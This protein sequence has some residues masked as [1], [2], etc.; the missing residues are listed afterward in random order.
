MLS[1]VK[2]TFKCIPA[3]R[4]TEGSTQG[5]LP[6]QKEG[7]AC[8]NNLEKKTLKTEYREPF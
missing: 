7:G 1:D 4:T 2:T 6:Y 3:S 5:G 8:Q